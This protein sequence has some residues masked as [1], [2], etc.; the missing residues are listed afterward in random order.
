M[1]HSSAQLDGTACV[2]CN[3]DL[4]LIPAPAVPVGRSSSGVQ[5]FACETCDVPHIYPVGDLVEHEDNHA[6]VC[7]PFLTMTTGGVSVILHGSLDGRER[8]ED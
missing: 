4:S 5:V 7:G 8:F 3:T 2:M 1:I 6:C